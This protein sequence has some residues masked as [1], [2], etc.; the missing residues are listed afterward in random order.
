[1]APPQNGHFKINVDGAVFSELK[2][3]GVGV[4]IRDDK[5]RLEAALCRK[6]TAPMGAIEAE[7]KAFEASL[8]FAKDVGVRDI[9]L[10]GNSLVVYNALCNIF[11]PLLQ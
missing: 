2:A 8:L 9:I 6:I 7:A 3:V 10:E 4:V 11:P 1:M 5:G